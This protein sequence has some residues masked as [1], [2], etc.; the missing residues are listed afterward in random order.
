MNGTRRLFEWIV[1][2]GAAL[3]QS[4]GV[5]VLIL[6]KDPTGLDGSPAW[7]LVIGM[8]Y[9]GVALVLLPW[10]RE[11]L[12]VLQR[13]WSLA[14]LLVLAVLSSFWATMPDLVIRRSIGL[15]GTT[16]LGV[17]LAICFSFQQQLRMFSWL[18][19]I[20]AV[21]SLGCVVLFPTYGVS[22]EGE[23]MGVFGYKNA[24]GTAMGLSL[25]VEW[26]L[27]ADGRV[28][29]ML[30]SLAM[31]LYVLLLL[32]SDSVTP[33]VAFAGAFILVNI[34][35]FAALRLRVPLYALSVII[36]I[37][38]LAGGLFVSG[39][40]DKVMGLLGRESSLTG[41][42]EIWILVLSF[43]PQHPI[44]GYGYGAF[45]GGASPE[46]FVVNRV[47]GGPVQY[48]HNGYL[49]MFLA[50][51]VMGFLLTLVFIGTG[52]QRA[53][54]LSRQPETEL[55]PLVFLLYFI[56]HN[57]GEVTIATQQLEWAMCVSFIA[58]TDLLLLVHGAEEEAGLLL[59]PQEELG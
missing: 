4:G 48:S 50:L 40:S 52:I 18:F 42:T 11:A 46:S 6:G 25:V 57:L 55:W 33:G 44:L 2:G 38:A 13:N 54:Y 19:R 49:E 41:R 10:Y 32:N 23:W 29:K 17:A 39:N 30:K 51:G 7:R 26:Q 1:L 35:K 59:V 16:L 22:S 58:G 34:Y 27:P 15:F 53:L 9:L 47:L 28:E 31:V 56:F 37:L 20:L 12:F 3:V 24:L 43:I 14:S 36:A 8:S 5:L 21:L 45:W